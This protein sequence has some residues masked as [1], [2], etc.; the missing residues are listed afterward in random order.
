M[1]SCKHTD[2]AASRIVSILTGKEKKEEREILCT[3]L[4]FVVIFR[5][6]CLH[7]PPEPAVTVIVQKLPVPDVR[8]LVS[9]CVLPVSHV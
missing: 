2:I 3:P 6:P 8:F 7:N 5:Y 1:I 4:P 9:L